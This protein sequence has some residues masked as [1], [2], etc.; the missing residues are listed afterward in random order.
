LLQGRIFKG[1][2]GKFEIS[3]WRSPQN[4]PGI[5]VDNIDGGILRI[6]L[7]G[8]CGNSVTSA[9]P[10]DAAPHGH[11]A[12]D[13]RLD[14]GRIVSGYGFETRVQVIR[15]DRDLSRSCTHKAGKDR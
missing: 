3:G 9:A 1:N 8:D 10:H 12:T 15:A 14:D 7:A 2:C 13:F 4:P 6:A 11:I 5:H